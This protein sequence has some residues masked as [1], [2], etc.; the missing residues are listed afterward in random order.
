[1]QTQTINIALPEDLVKRVDEVSG[2]KY[3]NPSKLIKWVLLSY[4]KDDKEWKEIFDYGKKKARKL[5]IKNE[6][7]I[8]DIVY[9]FRH[10]R[11]PS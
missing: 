8:D 10:G 11:K 2:K 1:M 7:E 3:S 4:L 9:E 6:K 5:G